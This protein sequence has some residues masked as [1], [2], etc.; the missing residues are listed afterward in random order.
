[1][2][3]N[4]VVDFFHRIFAAYKLFELAVNALLGKQLFNLLDLVGQR[5]RGVFLLATGAGIYDQQ[6]LIALFL[7]FDGL[8]ECSFA[9]GA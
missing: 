7:H 3:V 5:Q 2:R 9:F 8:I 6:W 1:M 4:Q